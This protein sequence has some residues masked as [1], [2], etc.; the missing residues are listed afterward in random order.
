MG[1]FSYI[2]LAFDQISMGTCRELS[3]DMLNQDLYMLDDYQVPT[4]ATKTF[5]EYFPD[6]DDII[7]ELYNNILL[8]EAEFK[9]Y[10]IRMNNLSYDIDNV[11]EQAHNDLFQRIT[12]LESYKEYL[13]NRYQQIYDAYINVKNLL[14]EMLQTYKEDITA[15]LNSLKV[16][17]NTANEKYN[18]YVSY[19]TEYLNKIIQMEQEIEQMKKDLELKLNKLGQGSGSF[20]GSKT[21]QK[22]E[23]ATFTAWFYWMSNNRVTYPGDDYAWYN[24]ADSPP[25]IPSDFIG[26]VFDLTPVSNWQNRIIS[27]PADMTAVEAVNFFKTGSTLTAIYWSGGVEGRGYISDTNLYNQYAKKCV[28][29]YAKDRT[30]S[31]TEYFSYQVK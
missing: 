25:D 26:G 10:V 28:M 5:R 20:S 8:L 24:F 12:T 29:S 11:I 19:E 31:V 3:L 30:I 6:K 27:K 15:F 21:V 9:N 22:I 14:N 23:R 7:E 1:R 16:K 2:P 13:K 18:L 4:S 17:Y